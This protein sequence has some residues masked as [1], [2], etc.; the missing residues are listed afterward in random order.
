MCA[1]ISPGEPEKS[2]AVEPSYCPIQDG[3]SR[4]RRVVLQFQEYWDRDPGRKGRVQTQGPTRDL[5]QRWRLTLSNSDGPGPPTRMKMGGRQ[6]LF[7]NSGTRP[8][9]IFNFQRSVKHCRRHLT[10][11]TAGFR[12]DS[13]DSSYEAKN[14]TQLSFRSH[15]TMGG[16]RSKSLPNEKYMKIGLLA[17]F[18]SA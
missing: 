2:G 13:S 7:D 14:Q 8:F 4:F 12:T 5:T 11:R 18:L 3:K 6:P 16:P 15:H 1:N 10:M 9:T 17:F